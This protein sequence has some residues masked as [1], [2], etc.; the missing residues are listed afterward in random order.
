MFERDFIHKRTVL[1]SD[2]VRKL[3]HECFIVCKDPLAGTQ[4]Q[5]VEDNLFTQDELTCLSKCEQRVQRLKEVVERHV[6]D[7]FTPQFFAKY[8]QGQM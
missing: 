2:Q 5:K 8:M 3:S 1:L 7:T 4:H 6:G